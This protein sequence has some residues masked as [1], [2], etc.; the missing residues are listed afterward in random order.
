MFWNQSWLIAT[1]VATAIAF[2][3]SHAQDWESQDIQQ[4][5]HTV[6]QN[7]N[8]TWRTIPWKTDLIEAQHLAVAESKPI[9]IWAMD[10]HPLGCT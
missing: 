8:E 2:E 5:C 7:P 4:L 9:F 3:S 6:C 10:G 1:A